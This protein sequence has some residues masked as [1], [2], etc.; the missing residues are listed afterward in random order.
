MED[1]PELCVNK[2][3]V[4]PNYYKCVGIR[5]TLVILI[6]VPIA[7]G[8]GYWPYVHTLLPSNINGKT[9]HPNYALWP[10]TPAQENRILTPYI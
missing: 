1:V 9:H 7:P 5:C 8:Q 6:N 10:L 3:R 4:R 2:I